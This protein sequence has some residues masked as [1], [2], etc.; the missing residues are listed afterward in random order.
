MRKDERDN[1]G[2]ERKSAIKTSPADH[3]FDERYEKAKARVIMKELQIQEHKLKADSIR[4]P[5]NKD[6]KK[7]LQETRTKLKEYDEKSKKSKR[8]DSSITTDTST[9]DT[10]KKTTDIEIKVQAP[11]RAGTSFSQFAK[12]ATRSVR[13]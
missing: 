5:W 1:I 3:S 2:R 8:T 10:S 9:G 6:Y 12:S 11:S 4:E 13:K 7:L